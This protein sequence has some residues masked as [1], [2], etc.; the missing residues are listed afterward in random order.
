MN[1]T[2]TVQISSGLIDTNNPLMDD[3]LNK[4]AVPYA[5]DILNKVPLPPPSL[6][7]C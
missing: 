5:I 1:S 6:F 2:L 4:A 3:I 7:L